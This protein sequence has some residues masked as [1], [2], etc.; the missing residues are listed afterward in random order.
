M[1]NLVENFV[2]RIEKI[3]A[4]RAT[5][6]LPGTDHVNDNWLDTDVYPGELS[7]QFLNGKL[8][9]T[10]G[11][12]IIELNRENLI[13]Y[14]LELKKSTSGVN[15]LTVTTGQAVING[16]TYFHQSAGTDVYVLPNLTT[17]PDLLFVYAQASFATGASG[18]LLS[19]L[20]TTAN[21]N[22]TEPGGV[23]SSVADTENY[24]TPP[25]N[26]L[27]LGTAL[28]YP[29]ATGYDLFPLT[30][31][32]FGDYYPKFSLSASEFLRTKVKEVTAYSLTSLFF[33]GQYVIDNTSNTIYLSKK[34]FVSDYS[35]IASDI[36][37]GNL[38][39]LGGGGTGGTGGGTMTATNVGTGLGVYKTTVGSQFQYRS[40]TS[41][42]G[43]TLAYSGTSDEISI[44]LSY[45]GLV[46]SAVNVGTGSGVFL[47]PTG[48]TGNI[49]QLRSLTAGSSN[50]TITEVG[51]NIVI[52]VPVIGTTAQGINLGT[53]ASADVYAGMSGADLTF[54]RLVFGTGITGSQTTDKIYISATG[55]ANQGLNIGGAP[56][57]IYA[58]MSGDDLQFR[59][60]T[61]GSNVTVTTIG[62]IIQIDS[63]GG[64]A[65]STGINI[66]ATGSTSGRIYAG[67]S[68]PDLTFRSVTSGFGIAVTQIGNDIQID[69]TISNGVTGAQGPQGLQG[70]SGIDGS[71][72]PQGL[73]GFGVTGTQ[74]A[75]GAQGLVGTQGIG[76][77][78][79]TGAQ[80]PQGALGTLNAAL[81]YIDAYDDLAGWTVNAGSSMYV[82]FGTTRYNSDASLFLPGT[83]SNPSTPNGTSVTI[84]EAGDYLIIMNVSG[85]VGVATA[86]SALA[87]CQLWNLT[88]NTAVLGT[89]FY[90]NVA[91]PGATG[92]QQVVT[93]SSKAI[94]NLSS[95][96]SY[97][98]KITV[99]G[100]DNIVGYADG[101]SISILK[102][103]SS[104]GA[105]GSDGATGPQ[106]LVGPTGTGTIVSVLDPIYGDGAT[107]SPVALSYHTGDFGLTST[108]LSGGA[109]GIMLNLDF[110]DIVQPTTSVA[111]AVRKNDNLTSLGTNTIIGYGT[112]SAT[113]T[114]NVTLPRGCYVDILGATATIPAPGA[115]FAGPTLV[116]G[117]W[118][119][120]PNP[121]ISL[122]SSSGV[123]TGATGNLTSAVSKSITIIKPSNGLLVSAGR[124]VR[125]TGNDSKSSS[126]SLAFNDLFY[127]GYLIVGPPLTPISQIEVDAITALQI[128]GFTRYKY[129]TK[130]QSLSGIDDSVGSEGYGA[131]LVF[132]YL[133]SAGNISSLLWNG[134]AVNQVGAFTR[135]T[136]PLT[137]TTISG[138]SYSYIY[139]VANA[140]NAWN[141]APGT[142][143]IS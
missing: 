98:V 70:L 34:T 117:D 74:G 113:M 101:S 32:D 66:G 119:Y 80:G 95:A 130:S 131:R 103:E 18:P 30:V 12:N 25:A 68:G 11:L 61:G 138:A 91:Y 6:P 1:A 16:V 88:A 115:G 46:T 79:V 127:F 90:L 126:I 33:P 135:G 140:A 142:M 48:S 86:G 75:A 43:I 42:N 57:L 132:G 128:Q 83:A 106:G 28:L 47:G 56:G 39:P 31:S 55:K 136:S 69:S 65:T 13:L 20:Y 7:V 141:T 89:N 133:A 125:P 112:I 54:R 24:P 123:Y 60:L 100:Q 92:A 5:V 114:G 97:A 77:T 73:I 59:S 108:P 137:I 62:N 19:I 111:W 110:T 139:Y 37:S 94:L 116:S 52:N 118:T 124:V 72:G 58:G 9:T 81:R 78:G 67:M 122:P 45:S 27:F 35:T 82:P 120:S 53:G 22:S 121:P 143:V 102:L 10:D 107:S 93:G 63:I 41:S 99:S 44:G 71:Q 87:M 2:R 96:T 76:S 40:L 15:K 64:G 49:L 50:I 29:G 17:K 129:G 134:G 3:V 21:G 23:Y 8:Y 4:T 105:T 85:S 84:Q 26:S 104:I 36:T 51:N 109:T 14:G 38:I